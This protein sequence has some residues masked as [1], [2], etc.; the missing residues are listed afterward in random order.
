MG[1]RCNVIWQRK[2]WYWGPTGGFLPR[3]RKI[4]EVVT[5]QLGTEG[6]AGIIQTKLRIRREEFNLD[7]NP[8]K[9]V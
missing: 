7:Q 1:K 3:H 4:L 8:V 9:D 2:Q 6:W 5:S